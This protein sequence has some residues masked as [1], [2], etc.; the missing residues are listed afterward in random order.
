MAQFQNSSTEM[1]VTWPRTKIDKTVPL[2]GTRWLPELKTEKKIRTTSPLKLIAEFQIN[3]AEM[4]I[5]WPCTKIV[6][7]VLFH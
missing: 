5:S 6:K 4:F 1:F 2:H 3:F 7:M